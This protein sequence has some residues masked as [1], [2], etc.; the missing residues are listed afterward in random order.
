M[1][2]LHL[3]VPGQGRILTSFCKT[4]GGEW[5]VKLDEIGHVVGFSFN[6]ASRM[7]A[8][9]LLDDPAHVQTRLS[10]EEVERERCQ[11]SRST[12]PTERTGPIRLAYDPEVN[13]ASIHLGVRG[14]SPILTSFSN[15]VPS[16]GIDV[17]AVGYVIG[18][19]FQAAAQTLPAELLDDPANIRARLSQEGIERERRE[20]HRKI[21]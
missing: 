1:A 8:A 19:E 20:R 12:T 2:L 3:S 9:P 13:M 10:T 16:L 4:R 15:D 11:R 14:E 18:F 7:L 21:G 6:P 5:G 17:D